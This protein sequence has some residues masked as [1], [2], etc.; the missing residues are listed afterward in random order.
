MLHPLLHF[1]LVLGLLL[2]GSLLGHTVKGA[3]Q[4]AQAQCILSPKSKEVCQ[5]VCFFLNGRS[6]KVSLPSFEG[7]M[8]TPGL[9]EGFILTEL[10]GP[11]IFTGYISYFNT[12]ILPKVSK[13]PAASWPPSP[14]RLMSSL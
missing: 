5:A 4:H 8:Q 14:V 9:Y 12:C 1:V 3:K 6:Y 10:P 2:P 13:A 7:D 11:S